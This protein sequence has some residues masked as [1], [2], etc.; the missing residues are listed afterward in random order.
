MVSSS[1]KSP[2]STG[3]ALAR[4]RSIRLPNVSANENWCRD[5]FSFYRPYTDLAAYSGPTVGSVASDGA[6]F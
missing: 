4:L 3:Q 5:K 6:N 1:K 2:R